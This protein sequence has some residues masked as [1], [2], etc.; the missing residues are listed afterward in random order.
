MFG[1]GQEGQPFQEA[2]PYNS[3]TNSLVTQLVQ[4]VIG[5]EHNSTAFR[6]EPAKEPTENQMLRNYR[7]S[8]LFVFV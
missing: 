2:G 3:S 8:V 6:H 7:S 4:R 5:T 1:T